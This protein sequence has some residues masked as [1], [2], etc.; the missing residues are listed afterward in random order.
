MAQRIALPASLAAIAAIAYFLA[1][2]AGLPFA[3]H[4]ALKGACVTI[5]AIAAAIAARRTDGWLLAGVMALGALGDM[6]LE[7]DMMVGA[8][9]FALGHVTAIWLY[10]RNRRAGPMP[11]S[12]RG[13]AL[14]LLLSAP[15]LYLIAGPAANAGIALYSALLAAMAAAAW[16]SRFS[17]YRTGIGAILFLASDAF[18]FARIGGRMDPHEAALFIWPLYTAGQILIF[19]G[20][21]QRLGTE[22]R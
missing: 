2:N 5:L 6:L 14:A 9:A 22:G 18:I 20:V 15:F 8:G 11:V 19:V 21:R 1:M 10:L 7:Y 17:R 16:T 12:Q 3:A 4:V 13:A